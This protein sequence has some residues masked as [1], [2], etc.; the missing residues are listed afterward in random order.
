LNKKHILSLKALNKEL[1]ERINNNINKSTNL[2]QNYHLYTDENVLIIVFII[3]FKKATIREVSPYLT[4]ED[5]YQIR[6]AE[7]KK[8]RLFQ[9]DFDH[10]PNQKQIKYKINDVFVIKTPSEHTLNHQY[11]EVH[12]DKWRSKHN[13][14]T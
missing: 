4:E 11:R 7:E 9:K 13:F 10:Y 8:K 14:F 3:V 2:R 6:V 1:K 12:K 5:V